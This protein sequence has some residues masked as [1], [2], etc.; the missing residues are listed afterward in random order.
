MSM[1][2]GRGRGSGH[3]PA[4]PLVGV[5]RYHAPVVSIRTIETP[6]ESVNILTHTDLWI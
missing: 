4:G 5:N 6:D 2:A 1:Q 3:A